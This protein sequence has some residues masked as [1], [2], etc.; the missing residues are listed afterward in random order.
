MSLK[1]HFEGWQLA[2]LTLTIAWGTALVVVPRSVVPDTVPVPRIEPR[3]AEK[4]ARAD[5][6][7][8]KS[9]VDRRPDASVRRLGSTVRAYG[10]K[11]AAHDANGLVSAK[12][13]VGAAVRGIA[14]KS[15]AVRLR[16]YQTEAFLRAV[17]HWEAT[18]EE[19][20][21]LD[22]LSG[23][24]VELLES[25]EWVTREGRLRVVLLDDLA[26]RAIYKKRW[27][28]LVGVGADNFELSNLER[29]ALLGFLIAHPPLPAGAAGS[30]VSAS[31]FQEQ[32]RIKKIEE[33]EKVDPSYPALY[34]KGIV[35]FRMGAYQPAVEAFGRYLEGGDVAYKLRAAN[36]MR[37]SRDREAL[38]DD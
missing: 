38:K 36:F 26:L 5:A 24:F 15:E 12:I 35:F 2:V 22:E 16:A 29:R 21:E 32:S 10:A 37:A 7:L 1:K 28:D 13:A 34:A 27:N 19:T 9:V 14:D 33:L 18:G 31:A 30:G 4:V 11:E 17:R 23:S 3:E 6:L 20:A 8:A 25:N